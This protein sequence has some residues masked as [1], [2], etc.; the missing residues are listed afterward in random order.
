[1]KF[2]L[3][4]VNEEIQ[5]IKLSRFEFTDS[6][7]FE[8]NSVVLYPSILFIPW[9]KSKLLIFVAVLYS[10]TKRPKLDENVQTKNSALA[11]W[12]KSS[13]KAFCTFGWYLLKISD[14][15]SA[16]VRLPITENK[17]SCCLDSVIAELSSEATNM[18]SEFWLGNNRFLAFWIWK[19]CLINLV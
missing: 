1:M 2:P 5:Q 6:R 4:L 17:L 9:Y 12:K 7:N 13:T 3:F 19:Y 10:Y 16:V 11:N 8:K 18:A 15:F 14:A